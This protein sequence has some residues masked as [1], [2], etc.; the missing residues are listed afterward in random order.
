MS[1]I[2]SGTML[3]GIKA[4]VENARVLEFS[5]HHRAC[6]HT[7]TRTHFVRSENKP[8]RISVFRTKKPVMH[9]YYFNISV[10]KKFNVAAIHF[11]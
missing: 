3:I 6:T 4:G 7:H 9:V 2:N 1:E 5:S 8:Y 11:E 10:N